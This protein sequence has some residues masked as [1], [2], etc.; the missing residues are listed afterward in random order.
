MTYQPF[1]LGRPRKPPFLI[2]LAAILLAG[3]VAQTQMAI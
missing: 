2:L 3:C 1:Q